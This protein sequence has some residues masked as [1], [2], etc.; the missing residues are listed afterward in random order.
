MIYYKCIHYFI[1]IIADVLCMDS[2]YARKY[3]ERLRGA[4]ILKE[5]NRM[6]LQLGPLSKLM[7]SNSTC[8][9]CLSLL[10]ET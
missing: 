10:T 9:I 5:K 1:N 3:D 8:L 4:D 7:S 6:Q 2:Q